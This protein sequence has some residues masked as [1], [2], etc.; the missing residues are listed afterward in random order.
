MVFLP[1][2]LSKGIL[3]SGKCSEEK[4]IWYDIET[5]LIEKLTEQF[6]G[7]L[8]VQ[9]YDVSSIFFADVHSINHEPLNQESC[10]SVNPC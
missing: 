7:V 6:V 1:T 10:Q 2:V 4:Q 5:L 3:L 8:C 9:S